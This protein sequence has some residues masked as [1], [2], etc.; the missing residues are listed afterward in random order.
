ME[1][2]LREARGQRAAECGMG[3]DKEG[4]EGHPGVCSLSSG[5]WRTTGGFEAEVGVKNKTVFLGWGRMKTRKS[6]CCRGRME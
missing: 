1:G 6:P 4:L 2:V 5:C 3:R